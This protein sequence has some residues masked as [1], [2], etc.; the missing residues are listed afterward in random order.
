MKPW[1]RT[2]AAAAVFAIVTMPAPSSA[3]SGLDSTQRAQMRDMLGRVQQ[4][5]RSTYFDETF[6]GIDLKAH[7]KAVQ[8][9]LEKAPSPA[10]A[11]A[12]I[13]QSLIDFNDSH[14][15][16]I[17]PMRPEK[18]EYGWEMQMIGDACFIVAVKP[19][20]DAEAKGLKPGDQLLRI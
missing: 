15:Y 7:F 6:K 19:G 13:A 20:S 18:Y 14:T 17:P 8:D 4:V 9:K 12:I 1:T 3:Q 2:A 16:F 11:Y 5:V 10:M